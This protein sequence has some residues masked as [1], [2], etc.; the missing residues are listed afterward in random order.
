MPDSN[1]HK[2]VSKEE[3]F[4][5]ID[6]KKSLPPEAD[7]FD[8]EAMEGLSMLTDRAKLDGLNNSIDEV[9]R[10]EAALSK[11]KRNIYILSAAAS[12]VLIIGI[13]FLLKD[14]SF[15]KKENVLAENTKTVNDISKQKEPKNLEESP[16]TEKKSPEGTSVNSPVTITTGETSGKSEK[17]RALKSFAKSNQNG[18]SG[19]DAMATPPTEV[20]ANL[21]TK[22]ENR[23]MA[24]EDAEADKDKGGKDYKTSL[25]KDDQLK[26]EET[27]KG[28]L[29]LEDE[30]Q[31]KDKKTRYEVNTVWTSSSNP[32]SGVGG[33]K[34]ESKNKTDDYRNK[35]Q[36]TQDGNIAAG[37][38]AAI[39]PQKSAEVAVHEKQSSKGPDKKRKLSKGE[40]VKPDSV[41]TDM[42]AGYSYY[43][44]KPDKG[45]VQGGEPQKVQQ[46]IT[47]V[48]TQNEVTLSNISAQKESADIP[49]EQKYARDVSNK[50]GGKQETQLDNSIAEIQNAEPKAA[51]RGNTTLE[52]AEFIGGKEELQQYVKKNLKISSPKKSGTIVAEFVVTKE[53]KIDTGTVKIT[54]K[55]KNCDPCSKDVSELVKTMPTWK[56]AKENGRVMERKQKLSVKYNSVDAVK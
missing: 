54:T 7:D 39:S 21:Q 11:K 16:A 24:G 28:D 4:K 1:K 45:I 8:K 10:Q 15:E 42:L 38:N 32:A 27:K 22:T 41:V 40:V 3:L 49:G 25:A 20:A 53:G 36:D 43:D 56:P 19:G 17:E 34:D 2:I 48:Q 51:V 50:K 26:R 31:E 9:L 47:P 29:K 23:N 44:Q 37:S 46:A 52:S 30:E 55:I 6:E 35:N 33:A 12:L 13:F 18:S 5:L 14:N